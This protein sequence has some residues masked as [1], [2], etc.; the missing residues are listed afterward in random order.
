MPIRLLKRMAW[1]DREQRHKRGDI[2]SSGI[3]RKSEGVG[4]S[5]DKQEDEDLFDTFNVNVFSEKTVSSQPNLTKYSTTCKLR[6]V[7]RWSLLF[8]D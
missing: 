1:Q 7:D 8:Y 4:R 2:H 5:D 3:S 6:L